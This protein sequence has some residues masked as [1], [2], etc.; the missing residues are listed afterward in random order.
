[1]RRPRRVFARADF[2][3]DKTRER[4]YHVYRFKHFYM[5]AGDGHREQR[6]F[7]SGLGR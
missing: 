2:T 6:R 1:M 7:L 4:V 3:L 5:S